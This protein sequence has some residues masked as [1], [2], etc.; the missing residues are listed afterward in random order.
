MKKSYFIFLLFSFLTVSS[1]AASEPVTVEGRAWPTRIK[2]GDE[3]K[4][5]L[6]IS[7]PKSF[8]ITLPAA[9]TLLGTFEIKSAQTV[10]SREMGKRVNETAILTLTV[11]ELGRQI[12]PP[13]FI[14]YKNAQGVLGQVTTPVISIEVISIRKNPSDKDTMRPIKG[15]LDLNLNGIRLLIFGLPALALAVCLGVRIFLNLR[16]KSLID[17]ESLKPPHERVF[18]ELG[19]LQARDLLAKDNQKE[20]YSELADI[21][22][23]YLERRFNMEVPELTTRE[24]LK[25]L[26]S[27]KFD[28]LLIQK[29]GDILEDTDLVK[30]A[31]LKAPKSWSD[32]LIGQLQAIVDITKPEEKPEKKK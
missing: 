17:P 10:S 23:R 11:F 26:R 21:L 14:Y 31:K 19:R 18:L 22:R 15:P 29:I 6:Q 20:F 13:F 9:Q 7:R 28:G 3:I 32:R 12:I 27:K 1:F 30:F 5:S 24:V 2:I 16:R 8:Q 4:L 25:E